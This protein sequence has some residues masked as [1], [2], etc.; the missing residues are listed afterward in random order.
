[1]IESIWNVLAVIALIAN[2]YLFVK[3]KDKT[4]GFVALLLILAIILNAGS[5]FN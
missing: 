5:V 3:T 1:V 2:A 4:A